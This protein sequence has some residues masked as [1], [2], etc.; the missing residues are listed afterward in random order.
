MTEQKSG[1]IV[2]VT[3][4]IYY[5]WF[6]YDGVPPPRVQTKVVFIRALFGMCASA[7]PCATQRINHQP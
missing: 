1:I 3:L 2:A 7:S 6:D 5:S 4:S